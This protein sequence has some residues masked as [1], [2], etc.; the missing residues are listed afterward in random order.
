[1][2]VKAKVRV[3][4]RLRVRVRVRV[5]VRASV[6]VRL[7]DVGR[8]CFKQVR[9]YWKIEKTMNLT[10]LQMISWYNFVYFSLIQL[11]QKRL[12]LE[13]TK[14]KFQNTKSKIKILCDGL[15]V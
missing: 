10:F 7:D 13:N 9:F 14:S 4:V 5:R 12:S 15:Q 8:F 11:I 3:G 2:R 1:M 6:R